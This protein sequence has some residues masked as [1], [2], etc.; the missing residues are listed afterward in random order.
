MTWDLTSY[1]AEF[2]GPAMLEFK[3]AIRTDVAALQ[4]TAAALAGLT[5]E[6]A[7]AWEEVLTVS[8]EDAEVLRG[9]LAH[10][11]DTPPTTSSGGS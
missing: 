3:E 10:G 4:Q 6:S 9:L 1:F 8:A 5:S 2:N 7:G 11:S